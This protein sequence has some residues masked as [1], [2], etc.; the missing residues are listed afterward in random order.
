MCCCNFMK[1][2][3]MTLTV[4]LLST[5]AFSKYLQD[6]IYDKHFHLYATT[7]SISILIMF[8]LHESLYVTYLFR[9]LDDSENDK[10]WSGGGHDDVLITLLAFFSFRYSSLNIQCLRSSCVLL[11]WRVS[12]WISLSNHI[13]SIAFCFCY[14]Y[15]IIVT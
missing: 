6:K 8:L 7:E 9:I 4:G 11:C 5:K 14:V 13:D 2:K 1:C 10:W 3:N 12:H 15:S